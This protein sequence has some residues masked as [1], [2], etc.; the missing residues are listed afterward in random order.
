MSM[1]AHIA[2][3]ERKHQAL[4]KRLTEELA[5][6]N[7]DNVRIAALKRQKLVLKDEISRLRGRSAAGKSKLH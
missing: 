6:P 4:D 1:T 7:Q 3:L 5:H 2:E